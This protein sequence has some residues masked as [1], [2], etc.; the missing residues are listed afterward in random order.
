MRTGNPRK[1]QR[2]L[3]DLGLAQADEGTAHF[4]TGVPVS[5]V[6]IRN[7][8]KS[9]HMG[10]TYG[11]DI[12]PAGRYM[13][14]RGPVVAR[15]PVGWEVGEVKFK[16][17]LVLHLTLDKDRI[18][19]PTGWKARLRD[20]YRLTG[21]ALS[22]ELAGA[23]FDG[24]VTVDNHGET[25]EIVD[26][27]AFHTPR[28]NPVVGSHPDLFAEGETPVFVALDD[29]APEQVRALPRKAFSN[30]EWKRLDEDDQEAI[31]EVDVESQA[32]VDALAD[33]FIKRYKWEQESPDRDFSSMEESFEYW[34]RDHADDIHEEM[35]VRALNAVEKAA[36]FM[37]IATEDWTRVCDEY[38][39]D[40]N[41][42]HFA[43]NRKAAG[44]VSVYDYPVSGSVYVEAETFEEEFKACFPDEV[45]RACKKMTTDTD[46]TIDPKPSALAKAAAARNGYL[47][48]NWETGDNVCAWIDWD[49]AAEAIIK[50]LKELEVADGVDLPDAKPPAERVV[51]RWPDGFYVQDLLPSELAAEGREMG[52]C[53]GRPDMGYGKAVREGEIKILSL[54]R[55]NGR[56][57][58]TIEAN[59]GPDPE[60]A[61]AGGKFITIVRIEQVKGKAN[62]L[63]GFDLGK[64]GVFGETPLAATLR[65]AIKRDEVQRVLEY[66][67]TLENVEAT[68]VEDLAPALRTITELRRAGDPWAEKMSRLI[69]GDAYVPAAPKENPAMPT[70]SIHGADCG[71]FCTPYKSRA[72]RANPW[73]GR[74]LK[75]KFTST[76]AVLDAIE[77]AEPSFEFLPQGGNF[78][79]VDPRRHSGNPHHRVRKVDWIGSQGYLV[80]APAE[81]VNFIDGNE[82]NFEHG[83][84][85]YD[86]IMDGTN[87]M[88][89]VPAGRIYR[90]TAKDVKQTEKYAADGE[91]DDQMG[92]TSPWTKADIGSYHAQLLDGNHRAAAALLAGE[93][94]IYVYVAE[95]SRENVLKKDFE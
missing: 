23:G 41:H 85:L 61:K 15:A 37:G 34:L 66:I 52:M 7:R 92:M 64:D 27:T 50:L 17:P 94:Y 6:Y 22:R 76:D 73:G 33:I 84:G 5:F 31:E 14:H 18:Y 28:R 43:V 26:L 51:H 95:N 46:G 40:T 72:A 82:W 67:N 53:V 1:K 88:L 57:L 45:A 19:G 16:T 63:P 54:R 80:L 32:R 75:S 42:Y 12:E 25:R 59:L 11:Q 38:L 71:G 47:E 79:P 55:P 81:N 58:F 69:L 36:G 78:E 4:E 9:P 39:V 13:L 8:E 49:S 70:C 35:P 44:E 87:A 24:I 3:S 10:A 65:A 83:R 30:E 29:M 89:E 2:D 90:V 86:G 48:W 91:L 20:H 74:R 56:P 60:T 93:P 77:N 21:E 68:E 62:R